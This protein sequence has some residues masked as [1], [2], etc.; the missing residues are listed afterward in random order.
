MIK[1]IVYCEGQFGQL[2]GKVANGLARCSE[3]YE[4]VGIIDSTKAGLDAG[5]YL[6]GINN[7]IPIFRNINDAIFKLNYIP[8]YYIYGIAP[9]AS[10]LSSQEREI[11]FN[12]MRM[13]MSIIN[14]MPEFLNDDDEFKQMQ[15]KY[16]VHIIDVRK[17]PERKDLHLFSGRIF[18][19]KTPIIAVFGTDCA[20]GKRTTSIKLVEALKNEGLNV[21]FVTTGQ[22]GLIQG[23]KYGI[24]VDVLTSGFM[25]GEIENE[26]VKACEKQKPDII[27]I[28]GQ[29]SLSHP[30]FTSSIA[31]IR[32]SCPKA[33]IVQHPP[34]RKFRCDFPLIPMP[35]L[36]SEI[37]LIETV[38][39]SK[40]IAITL[41][42][43]DMTDDEIDNTIIK[44]EKSFN[45]P[46][47]DTLNGGCEKLVTKLFNVF[48]ELSRK[49]RTYYDHTKIG[50]K[51][52]QD[53]A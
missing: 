8:D 2:D 34:K 36:E 20:V 47:T 17:P 38:S 35:T 37:N 33:I 19:I 32:G 42:H 1:A 14:G 15:Q 11:I 46:T 6:D 40:V 21:V 12:A 43:E 51:P 3:K 48:P 4:I 13:G 50:D 45:L 49:E 26:I 5:K 29:G 44:Y 41:N 30:A 22:T 7:K 52:F 23:S 31:I 53:R 9:L 25:T 27:I 24:A 18:D 16:G 10:F 28:E 39:D